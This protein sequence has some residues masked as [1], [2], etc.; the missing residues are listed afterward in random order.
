MGSATDTGDISTKK[1]TKKAEIIAA[2]E[3]LDI[4]A[5]E[6]V[7]ASGEL[8]IERDVQAYLD[9]RAAGAASLENINDLMNDAYPDNRAERIL[10]VGGGVA[11]AQILDVLTRLPGQR[12]VAIVDDNAALHG[13]SIL[14]VPVV[15]DIGQAKTLLAEER[16]DAAIISIGTNVE[17]RA[18]I[19][20][21]LS[22]DGI[23]FT[24]VIDPDAKILSNVSLGV[25]NAIMPF[26]QVAAATRV[27]DNNF[28]SAYVNLEH[29]NVLGSHC[30]FGPGVMTSGQVTIGSRV[31][32]GIGVF[33]EPQISIGSRSLIASG[34]V[35]TRSVPDD[36]IV[37]TKS[38]FMIRPRDV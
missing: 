16:F 10:I 25:G 7:P 29:H 27:G 14:G 5:L 31:K 21:R 4:A 28:L 35:L 15:G 30:T 26:V 2:R 18:S 1:W 20:E 12:A 34:V 13:K 38:N 17:I 3:G 23:P 11:C 37:K 8:I 22:G 9:S 19:Y 32:F 33:V 24:N 6:I 36:S